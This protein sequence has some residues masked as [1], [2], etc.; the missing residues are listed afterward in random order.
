VK[1]TKAI[2]PMA[3]PAHRELPL[4]HVTTGEG[5]TKRVVA[6]QIEEL[7][8]AGI[9]DI[10]LVTAPGT[11]PFFAELGAAF[12][13]SIELVEQ[14]EA[15]GFGHAVLLLEKWVGREPFLVQVCDHVFVTYTPKSCTQQLI[16]FAEREA[17]SV[18]AV[19]A[20]AESQLPYFGVVGGQ[21][22]Q[23]SEELFSVETVLEK[24]TPTV[25][26]QTCMIAGL[27]QGTYLGLFGTHALTPEVFACLREHETTLAPGKKLGLTESLAALATRERYL[28]LEV[29]GH[30]VDLEGPFG[31]LRAQL[32][33][34]L[35]GSRR[36]EVLRAMLEEVAQAERRHG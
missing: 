9:R 35:H 28:A 2:I 15:R 26:E 14:A 12:G 36:E 7:L 20:T 27:R 5:R 34:A 6:L 25:A 8:A 31:L 33:L 23:G 10:A 22:L 1:L 16:E 13:S 19:Q 3:G 32:A 29:R 30:R 4:Q 24:P 17:C 11:R 18:S 21:R